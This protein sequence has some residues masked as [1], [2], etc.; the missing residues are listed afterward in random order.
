MD[1]NQKLTPAIFCDRDGP[2]NKL[3]PGP[4]PEDYLHRWDQFEFCDGVIPALTKVFQSDYKFFVVSNQSGISRWPERMPYNQILDIFFKMR[5]AATTRVAYQILQNVSKDLMVENPPTL[6]DE[7]NHVIEDFTFCPHLP[8][9][10]CVCRKPKPGMLYDLAILH[11][12]S[13][14]DSWMIGDNLSDVKAGWNAGIRHNILLSKEVEHGIFT[15]AGYL[16]EHSQNKPVSIK[17]R[18]LDDAI[19]FILEHDRLEA[20]KNGG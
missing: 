5:Q 6:P 7:Q 12:I 14:K 8:E 18:S 4:P 9:D 20:E 10:E 17:L 1:N 15:D 11:H 16:R 13:M 2:I 19:D 3:L